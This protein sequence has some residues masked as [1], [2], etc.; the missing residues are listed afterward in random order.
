MTAQPPRGRDEIRTAALDAAERLFRANPPDGVSMR[1]I[2]EEARITYSLLNRHLGTKQ[3]IVDAMLARMEDRWRERT[4]GVGLDEAFRIM[5]GDD[6]DAGTFLRLLAWSILSGDADLPA[7]RRHS[8]MQ[9]LLPLVAEERGDG[10]DAETVVAAGMAMIYGWR[11]F[12]PFIT[13]MLD[14]E[15]A[16]A[17]RLHAEMTRIVQ[18]GATG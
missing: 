3:A 16:D 13:R 17:E 15:G 9:D 8:A 2:A 12:N 11:F 14:L 4:A 7:Y 18:A 5:M 10:A 6:P 1:A